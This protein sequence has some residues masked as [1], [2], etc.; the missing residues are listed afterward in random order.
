[1]KYKAFL[2][3]AFLFGGIYLSGCTIE[4]TVGESSEQ[5]KLIIYT[6]IFPLEDFTKKIG[7]EHVTVRQMIP[8][9]G[10]AHTYEPSLNDMV[11]FSEADFIFYNGLQLEGFIEPIKD[12]LSKKDVEIIG[13][14]ELVL[15]KMYGEYEKE[16]GHEE[17][18]EELGEVEEVNGDPHDDHS[19]I[20]PHIWLNPKN[21]MEMAKIILSELQKAKPEAADEF[22]E[23]YED[24]ADNFETLDTAF[25][26]TVDSSLNNRIVVA[27][28]AYGYWEEAYGLEQIAVNGLSTT[29]EPSQKKLFDITK[30]I[31]KEGISYI[32][33]EQNVSSR[34]AKILQ[35]EAGVE[36]LLLSNL[37]TITDEDR[38]NG[39]DYF[40]IMSRNI[41][42]LTKALN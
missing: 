7:G 25:K 39:E 26:E 6:S 17:E 13:I 5:E 12:S 3:F 24:I 34:I 8:D 23:N 31:E 9:G 10:D 20:D 4:Q 15:E 28:A 14:G 38:Q 22:R 41:E 29:E 35:E 2:L 36:E 18:N 33:F 1:M 32:I 42:T 11:K 19:D 40:S 21:A 27:H 16:E 37:A 30:L